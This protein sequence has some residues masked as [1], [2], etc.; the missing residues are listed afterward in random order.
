MTENQNKEQLKPTKE[1]TYNLKNDVI[2][3]TFFARKGNEEF[4][5]DFLNG[6]L[7]KD[8]KS[9]EIREEVNLERL[10]REEKG[11]RLDL[12]AKLEDGTI[13]SIEMQLRN[14]YN[15]EERTTL[16]SGKVMSRETERGTDY[17]DIK[18]V[19]MINILGYNF[20][21]VEDYISETAIVLEKHRAYEVLT[22]IKWYFIELP[23]FRKQNPDMNEKI[24][25]W[26]AFI[27]D[28]DREMVKVAEEKNEKLK[29]A[30]IEMNYLTGEAET[31]R[32]AELREKWE[33]DRVSAINHATRKGKEERKKRK[34]Y[35]NSQKNAKRKSTNRNDRKIYTTIKRRNRKIY[36]TIKRRN[37]KIKII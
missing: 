11:G 27:D 18:Q 29:K 25:Q 17:D 3:Q 16:Y 33:M 26:L 28:Y 14:E 12:Q 19:I 7:K 23:K 21:D 15:I 5:I 9:I 8:I 37:R 36:T 4:L 30:R 22:G 13:I 34:F 6:L 35:R 2:F 31:R 10:S 20:L 24:N 1:K 32:L